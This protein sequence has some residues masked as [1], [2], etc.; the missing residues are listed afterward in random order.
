MD[1]QNGS[2]QDLLRTMLNKPLYVA[3]RKPGNLA[4]MPELL[5]AHL[6]WMIAAEHRGELFA[7]GPFADDA[8]APGA[9]GG[10]TIVR[11]T[12]VSHARDILSTDPFVKEGVVTLD[13]K[14]W[15]LMEGSLSITVR[16]S[17]QSARLL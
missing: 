6:R 10:M 5:E 7:S 13:I 11:A 14:K 9:L 15:L 17:D 8:S 3:L 16:L 2:A 1:A 12:S 4:R